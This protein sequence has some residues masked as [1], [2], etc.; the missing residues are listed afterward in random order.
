MT[1]LT[2]SPGLPPRLSPHLLYG[3]AAVSYG[4]SRK[5]RHV[6][7]AHVRVYNDLYGIYVDVPMLTSTKIMITAVS[8]FFAYGGW[9]IYAYLDA[10]R[11]EI[12]MRGTLY[13]PQPPKNALD[14]LLM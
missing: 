7:N 11:A 12:N 10:N 14:Y 5:A 4:V 6:K 2:C 1:A 8:G 13:T 3:V 9:P